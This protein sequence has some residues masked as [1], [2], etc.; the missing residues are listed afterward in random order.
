ML[1]F[2]TVRAGKPQR[3]WLAQNLGFIDGNTKQERDLHLAP[4]Q[5]NF[6]KAE[7]GIRQ[8]FSIPGI[9]GP[10]CQTQWGSDLHRCSEVLVTYLR[11]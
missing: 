11:T 6:G 2:W 7:K 9:P 10:L 4:W 1:T 8:A 3:D 5:V